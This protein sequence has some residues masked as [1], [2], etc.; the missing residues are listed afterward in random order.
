[1]VS[2]QERANAFLDIL[3]RPIPKILLGCWGAIATWDTFVS[4][5]IPEETAKS[6]PKA[7]QV[8]S[9]TYGWLSIQTWLL[10]GAGIVVVTSLEYAAR[11]K[12]RLASVTGEVGSIPKR[13]GA[14]PMLVAFWL[15]VTVLIAIIWLLDSTH[16]SSNK[17][18]KI[19]TPPKPQAS[20]APAPSASPAPSTPTPTPKGPWVSNEEIEGQ[21]KLGRMLLIYS[22]QELFS[23]FEG[24]QNLGTF[25]LKWIKVEGPTATL[26]V[27]MKIQNK[28]YYRVDLKLDAVGW[29]RGAIAAL[30]DSKK[31]GD[32]LI[33]IRLG[34][35]LR[36]ICQY[37]E[38]DHSKIN[39]S[40][41]MYLDTIFAYNC[42]P[43]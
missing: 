33:N 4:Q 36:A 26:P 3:D 43:F 37:I 31:W 41:E 7:Y 18:Q 14:R 20:T 9:M 2:I 12:W 6:F 38:I 30:F 15:A 25:E 1:M 10:I 5:F 16:W 32:T 19:A 39:P 22:P 34:G 40:Y 11:H 13:D 42:E 8:I 23:M 21:R 28:D 29:N 24:G 27:V 17:D 35:K